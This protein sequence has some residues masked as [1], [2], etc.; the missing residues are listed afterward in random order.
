MISHIHFLG[1]C[2]VPFCVIHLHVSIHF[3][4]FSLFFSPF[5]PPP[6]P[7]DFPSYLLPSPSPLPF[8]L[9]PAG[10]ARRLQW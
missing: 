3:N 8:Y 4:C 1:D 2:K 9:L 6:P 5:L 7:P 10:P